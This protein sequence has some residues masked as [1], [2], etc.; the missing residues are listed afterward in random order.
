MDVVLL[1]GTEPQLKW[2]TF[3]AEMIEVVTEINARMLITLG[4]LLAEVPALP[5]R[6][7]DR[8]RAPIP[9]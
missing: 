8:H 7:G 2:R 5:A 3:C 1:I 4:A 6:L 9:R